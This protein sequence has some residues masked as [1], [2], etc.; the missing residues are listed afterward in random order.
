VL[1]VVLGYQQGDVLVKI[2]EAVQ[3]EEDGNVSI[4]E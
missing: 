3:L 4:S 2:Q 1:E